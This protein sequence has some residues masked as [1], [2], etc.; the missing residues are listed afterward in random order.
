MKGSTAIS[1]RIEGILRAGTGSANA[2]RLN[3]DGCAPAVSAKPKEIATAALHGITGD[4][5]RLLMPHTEAGLPAVLV[6]FL[7]AAGIF[8]GRTVHYL[9]EADHHYTNLFATIVGSTSKGRKGT[10]WGRIRELC[11][12]A[13][14][15]FAGNCITSGLSS[16]EGLIWAVRDEIREQIPI[17]E[18]G[19]VAGYEIAT[20]D[21]G[22]LDKRLLIQEPEFARV[23]KNAERETNNISAVIREAWDSG[24]LNVLTKN[25]TARATNAHIGIVAHITSQELNRLLTNT[26]AANGFANR[27]L[28]IYAERS[29]ELPFGGSLCKEDLYPIAEEL[30]RIRKY[31]LE[32][33]RANFDQEAADK[34]RNVYSLLSAGK[35]GLLGAIVARAEAQVVRL[36]T[37]YAL[38]DCSTL[39]RIAHLDA[40][41]AVWQYAEASARYIFGHALGDDTADAILGYLRSIGT[42]GASRTD[43]SNLFNRNKSTQEISRALGELATSG[44]ASMQREAKEAG[45]PIER[46]FAIRCSRYEKNEF[47]EVT[48]NP[49]PIAS[50]NS[51][52][53]YSSVNQGR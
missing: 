52:T 43:I 47:N 27:F 39:I 20:T 30:Q 14:E 10:S 35:P 18:K 48:T 44:L 16:G 22:V 33:T 36:A 3:S 42:T 41:L 51:L 37:L 1:P 34:W 13:D 29:K 11:K 17:K 9:A 49:A 26:E 31:G 40:A 24:S 50:L 2:R 5:L 23:L 4:L 12:I 25:K 21:A 28:W 38:L 53:S 8:F 46:W 7:V 19:R 32:S 15:Q 6:Q 45:A